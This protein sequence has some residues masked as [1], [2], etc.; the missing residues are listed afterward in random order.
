MRFALL[1]PF[2]LASCATSPALHSPLR[3]RLAAS[4][5]SQVEDATRNCLTEGGWKVDPIADLV[6]GSRRVTGSKENATTEV[7]INQP[8]VKPRITG[9]PDWGDPFWRCLR[10][11]LKGGASPPPPSS[12]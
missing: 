2:V 3:E 9:G 12:S 5:S 1:V 8:D 10:K 6:A 7:Y 4:D 11:A